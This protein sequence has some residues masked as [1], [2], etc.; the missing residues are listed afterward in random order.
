MISEL[1]IALVLLYFVPHFEQ[2]AQ[3]DEG[4]KGEK[5]DCQGLRL[6]GSN[7]AIHQISCEGKDNP[8]REKRWQA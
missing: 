6:P 7:H 4:K 5:D 1:F 3:E 8:K 2:D